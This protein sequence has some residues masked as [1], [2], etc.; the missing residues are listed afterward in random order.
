[1]NG[2]P[3]IRVKDLGKSFGSIDVLKGITVDIHKGDVVFVVGPSGSGKSTFL[4]MS[5][6]A[7]GAHRAGTFSLRARTSRTLRQTLTSTARKWE[8]YS[9]SL[10]CFPIWTIMK[11]LTLAPM[12]LQGKRQKEAE[13]EA[14]APLGESG[15]GRQGPRISQPALRRSEAANRHRPRSVH[16][17]GCDA[18][19]RA[20][21]R[22]GPGDGR[23]GIKRYARP[24][25]RRR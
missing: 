17:A 25:E 18:V 21:L 4:Q 20:H 9:S 11:N 13:E 15:T 1:M 22:A 7:G 12:K 14:M 23:R 19:R 6:P 16:E 8:W 5:E 10:T 2:Q 3:L 24:G